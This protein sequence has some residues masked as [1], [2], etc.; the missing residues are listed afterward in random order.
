MARQSQPIP[1]PPVPEL[2]VH[3]LPLI[4]LTRP[5]AQSERFAAAL[6]QQ[7][8][9]P[10]VLIAPLMEAQFLQPVVPLRHWQGIVLTSETGVEAARRITAA[11]ATLPERAY[12]VGDRTT[13]AARDAG[14]TAISARG[15]A[16][17]LVD[18]LVARK[19]A[20]PLLHLHG[21]ASRGNVAA[22]LSAAGTETISLV[23]YAQRPLPAGPGLIAV[24]RER[25]PV[26]LPL[27]SPRSAELFRDQL[28]MIGATAPIWVVAMSAAVALALQPFVPGRIAVARRPD[29]AA[30]VAACLAMLRGETG[31]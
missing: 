21:K 5:Q 12:C 2:P 16:T 9:T 27:F 30:M 22:R 6:R 25:R 18:D 11:G 19:L 31:S 24:L 7:I 3:G 4:L 13:E 1:A 26:L 15:A 8:D 23:G 17:D 29:G 10:E 14:F 28:A 20:G